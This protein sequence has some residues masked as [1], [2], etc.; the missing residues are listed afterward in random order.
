MMKE[1]VKKETLTKAKA[2]RFVVLSGTRYYIANIDE[3]LRIRL[4]VPRGPLQEQ[5]LEGYHQ[6]FRHLGID[7]TYELAKIIIDQ[8]CTRM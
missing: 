3:N 5:A 1:D 8:E 6:K 7:K 4:Y 2:K